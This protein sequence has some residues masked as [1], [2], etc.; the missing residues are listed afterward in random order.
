[1]PIIPGVS[2]GIDTGKIIKDLKEVEKQPIKRLEKQK[3]EADLEIKALQELQKMTSDLQ[4][5][6]KSLFGFGANYETKKFISENSAVVKGAASEKAEDGEYNIEIMSLASKL[7]IG[8]KDIK[9]D[10]QIPKGSITLNGKKELFSGGTLN[11]FKKFLNKNYSDIL[12]AKKIRISSK[13][14]RLVIASQQEGEK[15]VFSIDDP[16]KLLKYLGIFDPTAAKSRKKEKASEETARTQEEF[17]PVLFEPNR[18]GVLS[19]GPGQVSRDQRALTLDEKAARELA[20]SPPVKEN[21]KLRYLKLGI[22][23]KSLPL[24]GDKTPTRLSFG[25]THSL[26]I[27]GII[28]NTYN[29]DRKRKRSEPAPHEFDYGIIL[30]SKAGK[31]Q[32]RSLKNK[33]SLQQIPIPED[34]TSLGFYT[35]NTKVTFL[36]PNWVYEVELPPPSEK[37]KKTAEDDK[38]D[39]GFRSKKYF[40]SPDQARQERE[41]LKLT[42]LKWNGIP[43]PVLM[44]SLRGFSLIFSKTPMLR[45][46]SA[47]RVTTKIL[48]NRSCFL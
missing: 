48:K 18:M 16:D 44:I 45:S 15:G 37:T 2:S 30:K 1:M 34:T 28:L 14:E 6:A 42:A 47:Y 46:G 35:Q 10:E 31:P 11:D 26:N 21:A 4:K 27:K 32:K 43:I 8:S 13:A 7:T 3:K 12:S 25:P 29:A 41:H 9:P 40:P 39:I 22:E 38:V 17:A 19:E 33:V 23:H 24:P 20:V 36:D 5:G